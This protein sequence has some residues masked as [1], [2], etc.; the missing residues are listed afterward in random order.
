MMAS[1]HFVKIDEAIGKRRGSPPTGLPLLRLGFRP[2]YLMAALFAAA[3]VP[4]WLASYLGWRSAGAVGLVWHMHEMVFGFGVAVVIGFLLTAARNWSGLWTPRGGALAALALLW[5]AGRVAMLCG[6]AAPSAGAVAAALIDWAFL[7]AA[8]WPLYDVL[9][10]SGKRRNL[11]LLGI[12]ALLAVA[13]AVF[14]AAMA[15]ALPVSPLAAIHAALLLIVLLASI[16]GGRVIPGF[17]ANAVP[18]L[19]PVQHARRDA[20]AIALSAAASAAWVLQAPGALTAVLCWA[21]AV[22]VGWRLAGW[23]PWR[24]GG[25]PLLWA[26][27]AGYGWIALGY[28]LLGGAAWLRGAAAGAA[29]ASSAWHALA[30]GAMAGMMLAMMTRTALGHTGRVLRASNAE[31]AMFILLQAG[32]VLRLCANI[33]PDSNRDLILLSSG[34][35]WCTAFLLYAAVYGP[36]L[37][38]P[39]VDGQDG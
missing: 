3:A 7:P 30:V 14:H 8:A 17:T 5:L 19:Q 1:V 21:A 16:L 33:V 38:Q 11:P 12:V 2:F 24:T 23:Q 9:T 15:G 27:H 31:M 6:P 37:S 4:L 20:C 13:N 35:C 34:A 36:Y 39:R 10:R 22:L 28:A 18:G 32:A 29:L 26:L 25:K